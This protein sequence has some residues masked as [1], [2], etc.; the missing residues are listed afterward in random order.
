MLSKRKA[1]L[2]GDFADVSSSALPRKTVTPLSLVACIPVV[3]SI[4]GLPFF[5]G[6]DTDTNVLTFVQ[7]LTFFTL[8][9][10]VIFKREFL[11]GSSSKVLGF[12]LSGTLVSALWST[13]FSRD[14][15]A[16]FPM[17]LLW[18]WVGAVVSLT[19]YVSRIRI[20]RDVIVSSLAVSLLVQVLWSY[21]DWW[22]GGSV[23]RLHS[24]TFYAPNQY[25]GY[26]VLVAPPLL[27]LF[28]SK[29]NPL[30][31]VGFGLLTAA[32]YLSI[33]FSG[34]RGGLVAASVGL[35][36]T[37]LLASRARMRIVILRVVPL[38]IVSS[39][40]YFLAISSVPQVGSKVVMAK[41]GVE[42]SFNARLYWMDSA[43]E[44]GVS[45]PI[46]GTG[47]G[48]F[49][50]VLFQRQEPEE[51]WSKYVH[52]HYLE[53]FSDGGVPMLVAVAAMVFLP[54]VVGLRR[55][56]AISNDSEGELVAGFAGGLVGAASH[57]VVDHDWSYPAFTVAF[58]VMSGIFITADG[59]HS[60]VQVGRPIRATLGTV[61]AL[62]LLSTICILVSA[63]LMSGSSRDRDEALNRFEIAT[64]LAPWDT[65]PYLASAEILTEKNDVQSLNRALDLLERASRMD[66]LD[67]AIQ[68]E[69]ASIYGLLGRDQ[70]ARVAYR[71]AIRIVPNSPSAYLRAA[72]FE[73]SRSEK[74]RAL[75]IL[76][77]GIKY[78][79]GEER[80]AKDLISLRAEL[81]IA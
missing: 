20:L 28:L 26:V 36:V 61:S 51:P 43:L 62:A 54:L 41:T 7:A 78:F 11:L 52:N 24:G 16:S 23:L 4:V 3:V 19:V 75:L 79:G 69:S 74:G 60:T 21:F 77:E 25:A 64:R 2:A 33:A 50:D 48:T 68:W 13:I 67:P 46:T 38:L 47:L 49:G 72:L 29:T 34:S 39:A 27:S 6:P 81:G 73:I 58:V 45:R 14:L 32:V 71:S 76:N 53:A 12:V 55:F 63:N 35:I 31:V 65:A 10:V 70:E 40:I 1:V 44:I 66:H 56:R 17:V 18:A 80:F 30:R 9:P 59:S 37:A 22:G 5:S 42:G 57:L 8:I 15:S